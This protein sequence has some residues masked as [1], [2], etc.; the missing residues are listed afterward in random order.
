MKLYAYIVTEKTG[1]KRILSMG[2]G[3]AEVPLVANNVEELS[4]PVFRVL[5]RGMRSRGLIVEL[6]SFSKTTVLERY[7]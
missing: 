2:S 6:V 1:E 7:E 4:K 5:A 3:D